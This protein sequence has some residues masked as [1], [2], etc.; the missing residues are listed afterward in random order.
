MINIIVT[1]VIVFLTIMIVPL[2]MRKEQ[3]WKR[4][5]VSAAIVAVLIT[6]WELFGAS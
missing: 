5:L 1:V 2:F 4:A 6:L 3:T